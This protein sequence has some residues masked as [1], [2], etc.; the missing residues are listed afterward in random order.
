MQTEADASVEEEE[1]VKEE[2]ER[3]GEICSVNCMRFEGPRTLETY[4]LCKRHREENAFS[5][6]RISAKSTKRKSASIPTPTSKQIK[7]MTET[8][9]SKKEPTALK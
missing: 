5:K 7:L 4:W 1:R 6:A 3:T 8:F 2:K 9:K